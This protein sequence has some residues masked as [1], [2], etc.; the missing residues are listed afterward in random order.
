MLIILK[1]N[2]IIICNSY[3][4]TLIIRKDVNYFKN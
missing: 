1:I 3:E 2:E 4:T